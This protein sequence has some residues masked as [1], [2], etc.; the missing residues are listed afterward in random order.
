MATFPLRVDFRSGLPDLSAFPQKEWAMTY[1]QVCSA[2]PAKAFGYAD[3]EGEPELREAIARYLL[4]SRGIVCAPER[5]MITSGSTQGLWLM[6]RLLRR[7]GSTALVEDPAHRGMLKVMAGAGYAVKGIRADRDGMDVS[8]L[9][10]VPSLGL[11]YATPSH[12]YPLGG[13]LPVQ[14]RLA[15]LRFARDTDSYVIEDD[16]DSEF[17]YAGSPVSALYELAPE[18]VVYL[19][20]FSKILAPA[21]QPGFALLPDACARPGSRK[22]YIRMCTP[23]QSANASWPHSSTAAVWK[24]TSGK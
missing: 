6:A 11:I 23:T 7:R 20:S 12:Q 16:Y 4:R 24:S 19:G 22:K 5:V 2:L 9:E 15:L 8:L 1:R 17:R 13:I 3:P 14:R 10:P 18:R 21:L